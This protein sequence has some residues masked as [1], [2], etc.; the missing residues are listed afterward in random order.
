[1]F[2]D[3][4][5]DVEEAKGYALSCA[6]E[7]QDNTA[8]VQLVQA[9]L[10]RDGEEGLTHVGSLLQHIHTADAALSI[11]PS[12]PATTE[13]HLVYPFLKSCFHS[14]V[15]ESLEHAAQRK[16]DGAVED[17]LR[18]KLVGLQTK[19]VTIDENSI[20]DVCKKR[21]RP[22][23]S[24]ACFPDGSVVHELCCGESHISPR[25]GCNFKDS[26]ETKLL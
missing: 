3:E 2:L 22:N 4:A 5:K 9:L 25:T 16:M 18:T 7:F 13:L 21:L 17:A 14:T 15:L 1:M 24:I 20:C 19:Q 6:K 11:L 8:C 26:L 10:A 12:L 23:V